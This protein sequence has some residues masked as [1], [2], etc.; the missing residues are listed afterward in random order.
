MHQADPQDHV[1]WASNQRVREQAG[2]QPFSKAVRR[3][4]LQLLGKVIGDDK[5]KVLKEVT[6]H[7]DTLDPETSAYVRRVGRPKQNWTEQLI[8]I[9]KKAAGSDECW[10]RAVACPKVWN[11][12]AAKAML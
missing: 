10:Q 4:Q 11:E 8:T 5:K 2:V 9:M 3:A 6:F 12:I 7:G 1:S